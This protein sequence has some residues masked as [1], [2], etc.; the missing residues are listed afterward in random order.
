MV[1]ISLRHFC[2]FFA[3]FGE[4]LADLLQPRREGKERQQKQLQFYEES[5]DNN[6]ALLGNLNCMD[7]HDSR[8]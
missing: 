3:R 4:S 1:T 8:E 2:L 5:S 7:S 6:T